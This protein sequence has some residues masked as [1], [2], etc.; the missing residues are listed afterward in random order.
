[1]RIT[2]EAYEHDLPF[3][4]IDLY[5]AQRNNTTVI[6]F[7]RDYRVIAVSIDERNN[8]QIVAVLDEA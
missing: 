8:N 5:Q 1:M 4:F 6:L 3:T 2:I 7:N